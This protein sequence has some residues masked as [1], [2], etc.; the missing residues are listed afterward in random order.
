MRFLFLIGLFFFACT[1]INQAELKTLLEAR[2]SS[3][4][5]KDIKHY[6]SLLSLPYLKGEGHIKVEEMK[7]IFKRFDSV[8]M[9]SRDREIR[10]LNDESAICE[11]TYVLK[12]FADGEWREIVQREQLTFEKV[13][14]SWKISGGI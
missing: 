10:M 8:E 5:Q 3:I 6:S 11:Q 2:D 1:D 12:V 4:S 13:D 7:K 14:G 9:Q